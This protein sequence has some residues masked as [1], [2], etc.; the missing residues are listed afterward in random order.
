MIYENYQ[1]FLHAP[2]GQVN[3]EILEIILIAQ[4]METL[5]KKWCEGEVLNSEMMD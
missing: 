3:I 1:F 5:S 4:N 2:E